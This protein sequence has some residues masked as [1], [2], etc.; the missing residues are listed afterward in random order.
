MISETF[1]N[2]VNPQ[3]V[4]EHFQT[5]PSDDY[6]SLIS[7]LDSQCDDIIENITSPVV[8]L[9]NNENQ[10][11]IGGRTYAKT[12]EEYE[13]LRRE[14]LEKYTNEL[15]RI[16]GLQS[17]NDYER[18]SRSLCLLNKLFDNIKNVTEFNNETTTNNLEKE[19]LSREN[20]LMIERNS[21][22][23]KKNKDL[24]LV[25]DANVIGTNESKKK[26]QIQYLIFMILIIIFLVIQLVIFFV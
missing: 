2:I 9:S 12:D 17:L 13:T 23:K 11:I 6:N 8:S 16:N 7:N 18:H 26:I 3:N 10:C 25:T 5:T 24:N 19:N 21:Q 15:E 1:Q 20:E 4:V 14:H 22:L